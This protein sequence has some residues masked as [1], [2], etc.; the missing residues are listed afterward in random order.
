MGD[1]HKKRSIVPQ[2][3]L[4]SGKTPRQAAAFS[5]SRNPRSPMLSDVPNAYPSWQFQLLDF[6]GPYCPKGIDAASLLQIQ[7]KLKNFESM[8]WGEIEG[9]RHHFVT[10]E[11]LSDAAKQR[12]RDIGMDDIDMLFSLRLTGPNRIYGPRIGP[13][14]KVLWW[15]PKHEACPSL[16]ADN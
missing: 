1:K 6:D 9:K 5:I 3:L 2:A 15:D 14:M 11:S 12:L 4:E 16:G 13:V 7:E 10:L 8:T